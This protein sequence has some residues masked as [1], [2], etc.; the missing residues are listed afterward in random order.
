LG[1]LLSGKSD[2]NAAGEE[3][4]LRP[5]LPFPPVEMNHASDVI[6]VLKEVV[7]G[8]NVSVA[9]IALAWLI[10]QPWV[11][12]TLIG[13]KRIEQLNDNLGAIDVVFG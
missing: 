5:A 1:G 6:D 11:I 4:H 13:A 12:M 2:R 3:G 7:A 9:Q 10:R 8:K